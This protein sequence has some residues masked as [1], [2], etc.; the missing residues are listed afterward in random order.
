MPDMG[1]ARC[2][3][4]GGS[5]A[6][7]WDSIQRILSLPE[8]TRIFSCHDYAPDGRDYQFESTVKQQR[9]CNKHVKLGTDEAQFVKWRAE[10]DATLTLPK[11]L[12]WI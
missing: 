3:F 11:L 12:V 2:D 4:P 6:T 7:L 9:E 10:R 8:N 1:T 5:S